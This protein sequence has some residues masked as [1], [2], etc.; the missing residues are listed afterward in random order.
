MRNLKEKVKHCLEI[1]KQ[2][3]N[4]D[5]RLTN[6]IYLEYYPE[7]IV[8]LT[9]GSV[10]VRLRDLYDLPREDD[11]KRIRALFNSKGLYMPTDPEV[12]NKRRLNEIKWRNELSLE[13]KQVKLLR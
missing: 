4:S 13:D 10:A 6:K 1:D 5:I 8:K 11:V 7:K 12:L 3:R 2:S 9:D